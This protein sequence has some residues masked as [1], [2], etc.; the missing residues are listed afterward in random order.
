MKFTILVAIDFSE[1]S[2][3]VLKK[4]IEFCNKKDGEIHVVHIIEKSIFSFKKVRNIDEI[5]KHS[6][7]KLEKEFPTLEYKNF[8]CFSGAVKDEIAKV[9]TIIKADIVIIG[10]SGENFVLEDIFIGSNTKEIVRSLNIPTLV[11]KSQH[12]LKYNT[13]LIPTDLSD[14]SAILI[15]KIVEIFPTSKLKLLNFYIVPFENRL[16]TYGFDSA[17]VKD[18]GFSIKSE[19]ELAMY[20]FV[21]KLEINTNLLETILIK[22]SLN[23]KTFIDEVEILNGDLV[24]MHTTGAISF[25]A[26]D[27]LEKSKLDVLIYRVD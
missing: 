26:F 2:F 7:E 3:S 15:K 1:S 8:H 12:E 19:S 21:E 16:N 9:A 4:A 22:G 20:K 6:W 13:I 24:A 18:F 10:N 5:S 25:F 23:S 14:Y 27:I 17:E 11:L